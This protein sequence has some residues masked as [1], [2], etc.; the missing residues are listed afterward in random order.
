MAQPPFRSDALEVENAD[1]PIGP[2]LIE[3]NELNGS[4]RF[5]DPLIPGGIDLN[6]LVGLQQ[7]QQTVI[8]SQT[9]AAGTKDVNGNP[10]TTIQGALDAIPTSADAD[11][12][13]VILLM[14]G[15]YLE[16]V[17]VTKDYTTIVGL[18]G[19]VI[20]NA[21]ASSTVRVLQGA[22]T[23]PRKLTL[24]NLRIENTEPTEACVD[25]S[26]AQF[27]TGTITIGSVPNIGDNVTV[28][29]VNLSAIING[30]IPAPG[31]FEIGLTPAETAANLAAA[32]TDPVNGL[33][34][35]VVPLVSGA[36][37]ILRAFA[38]GV[39]GNAITLATSVAL[40]LVISGGTFTGGA[41]AAAASQV[42]LDSIT[43]QDCDLIPSGITGYQLRAVAVNNLYVEGGDWSGSSTGSSILVADCA[44]C[45]LV[46]IPVCSSVAMSYD[47]TNPE[48]PFLGTSAYEVLQCL[49]ATPA[50]SL[51]A[52]F[53]GVGSLVVSDSTFPGPVSYMGDTP[54]QSLTATRCSFGPLTVAGTGAATLSSCSRGALTAA[55]TGT[56]A[57]SRSYGSAVFVAVATVSVVFAE[58][59]PNTN[60][61]VILESSG[62]PVAVTDIPGVP[63]LSKLATG[64][65]ISFGAAQTLT[66]NYTVLRDI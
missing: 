42:G 39:A 64:F 4:L 15:L 11:E 24:R 59:Q 31:E 26:S 27:A 1:A 30:G 3:A 55:G 65:D 17:V 48:L 19:V 10:I 45:T 43:I 33:T 44:S 56:L 46:D 60:Y 18:G 7:A 63:T 58:P 29:G 13:Y 57:E 54:V 9:G 49:G 35:V 28:G 14:P 32:V 16:D 51:A 36:V 23:T 47:N 37:V 50:T 41:A 8:V 12:Q 61:I 62:P 53:V 22:L 40:V 2:R 52:T 38:P 25:V 5:T 21:S 20:R 34:S 6:A 66:V